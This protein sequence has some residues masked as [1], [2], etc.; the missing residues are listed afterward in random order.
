MAEAKHRLVI[1]TESK[2]G[3]EDEFNHWYNE[4]HVKDLLR[5]DGIESVQ[6]FQISEMDPAQPAT[7][8]WLGI[9]ELSRDPQ[10]VVDALLATR[11]TRAPN[12]PAYDSAR[13]VRWY[14]TAITERLTPEVVA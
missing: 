4:I 9:Y 1:F 3:Q 12:S 5:I 14:Y 10:E 8:R 2:P 6:R 7:H 13:T 11:D